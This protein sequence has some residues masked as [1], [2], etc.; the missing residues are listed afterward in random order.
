MCV[1]YSLCV[2]VSFFFFK[3]KTAYEMRISDWSSDVC[4][5]DLLA[6]PRVPVGSVARACSAAASRS[7]SGYGPHAA[8][9]R[10]PDRSMRIAIGGF[11][12]ETNTFAPTK[13]DY[14]AFVRAAGW[15]GL[16]PW[17]GLIPA[18]QEVGR[19]LVQGRRGGSG[20]APGGGGTV[21]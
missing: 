7:T 13:A 14:D 3:Q 9:N 2:Y 17:H 1:M 18:G 5:S 15:P 21:K 11:H 8:R 4:S 19:R 20:T 10:F 12:H 16:A 6:F